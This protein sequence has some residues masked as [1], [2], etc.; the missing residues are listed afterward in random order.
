[1]AKM[2]AL[3]LIV[4]ALAD[5]SAKSSQSTKK[6]SGKIAGVPERSEHA[7][8]LGA[9]SKQRL[10]SLVFLGASYWHLNRRRTSRNGI[11]R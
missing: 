5:A 3:A 9:A 6:T 10:A 7:S 1:M 4:G 11:G 8:R 2:L